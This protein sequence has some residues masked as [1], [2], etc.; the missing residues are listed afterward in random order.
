VRIRDEL[1]ISILLVEQN[2]RMALEIGDEAYVMHSGAI[3]AHDT[4]QNLR[5][6]DE[7]RRSYLGIRG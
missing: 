5:A 1:G 7:I 2:S 6:N 3:V 4:V